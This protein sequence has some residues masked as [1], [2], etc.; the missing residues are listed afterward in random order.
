[1]SL[2]DDVKSA[3]EASAAL[4]ALLTGEVGRRGGGVGG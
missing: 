1:M 2:S 4:M 3:L